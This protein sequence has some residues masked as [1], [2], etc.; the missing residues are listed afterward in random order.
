MRD[1]RVLSPPIS[2]IGAV[3]LPYMKALTSRVAATSRLGLLCFLAAR[4]KTHADMYDLLDVE[5]KSKSVQQPTIR[6]RCPTPGQ[7][8]EISMRGRLQTQMTFSTWNKL[9]TTT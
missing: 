9:P 4:I 1:D 3:R 2:A 6:T 7:Q 5:Q 8:N